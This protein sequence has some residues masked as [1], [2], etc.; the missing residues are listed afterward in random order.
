M[1]PRLIGPLASQKSG[2]LGLR[3]L[4][5]GAE[6][7]V[8]A[9]A[10]VVPA[11]VVGTTRTGSR[12]VRLPL[13]EADV[14]ATVILKRPGESVRRGEPLLR[15]AS[16]FGLASTEYVCPV[17]GFVE[18]ILVAERAVLIREHTAEVRAGVAGQVAEI[19][20][21]RG[22]LLSFDGTVARFFAGWGPP[23]AGTLAPGVELFSAADV[24]RHI[25]EAN[26]G[27]IVWALSSICSEAILEAARIEAA[28]IIAG[29]VSLVELQKAA[30]EIRVRTGRARLP[31][32]ML[33]SEGF[34]S[35]AMSPVFRRH[36]SR[37]VGQAV[38]VDAG[39]S[40]DLSWAADPEV[41]FS[42]APRGDSDAAVVRTAGAAP[43]GADAPTVP[44]IPSPG[45]A[46]RLVDPDYLGRQGL[47]RRIWFGPLS[48]SVNCLQAEVGLEDG[49]SVAVP[50]LN[51]EIVEA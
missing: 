9:G 28:G 51:L 27:Q 50:V 45:T 33:I 34:G 21:D 39:V 2:I 36:L 44:F 37:A 7:Q 40:G 22:V 47:V 23:V 49:L 20:A 19:I 8:A 18:E 6:I 10:Q 35:L 41:A 46:V 29:S 11:T 13:E 48:T 38:Y 5:L 1:I 31:L 42:P 12:V 14:A 3:E 4:G 43:V 15:R 32:T 26:R 24:G 17:D 25:T 30:A 16:F